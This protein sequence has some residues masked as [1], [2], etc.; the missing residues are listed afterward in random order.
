MDTGGR[1]RSGKLYS[2]AH[3]RGVVGIFRVR[4]SMQ[5]HESSANYREKGRQLF[6]TEHS[7]MHLI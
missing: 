1:E 6:G 5:Y 3:D 4:K 7:T 2:M